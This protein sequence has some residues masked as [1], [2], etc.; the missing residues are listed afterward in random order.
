VAHVFISYAHVD[1]DFAGRLKGEIEKAGFGVWIDTERLRAGEDW[2]TEIDNAVQDSIAL[3]LVM[4]PASLNSKYV[5]YEWA[6]ALGVGVKVVPVLLAPVSYGEV[7]PR[8]EAIQYLN[9]TNFE[10]GLWERLIQRLREV[11]G[12]RRPNAVRVSRDAPP[13]VQHAVTA[14]DSHNPDER[15]VALESLSQMDH[16][17]AKD[18]LVAAMQHPLREVRIDAALRLVSVIQYRDKQ[19]I[20]S[21]LEA[22]EAPNSRDVQLQAVEALGQIGDTEV[23]PIL[24]QRLEGEDE[25]IV[26]AA[27][28]A[29]A[30]IGKAATPNLVNTLFYGRDNKTVHAAAT[31]LQEIGP[32]VVP[33]LLTTLSQGRTLAGAEFTAIQAT[34]ATRLIRQMG[35]DA[36]PILETS[37]YRA[38]DLFSNIADIAATILCDISERGLR[39]VIRATF[40][41]NPDVR[42]IAYHAFR[43]NNAVLL[44]LI[45][46]LHRIGTST[47]EEDN[48][49]RRGATYLLIDD[50]NHSIT[51]L[52]N[53]LDDKDST[54]WNTVAAILKR[55]PVST[56]T[57]SLWIKI[58]N[59]TSSNSSSSPMS[60]LHSTA[61]KQLAEI[62][63][64][65]VPALVDEMNGLFP[66]FKAT[67]VSSETRA[68]IARILGR[69]GGKDAIQALAQA[70]KSKNWELEWAARDALKRIGTP[71]ALEI[72]KRKK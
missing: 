28:T 47:I 6:F 35:D 13:A 38:N 30:S 57:V 50:K 2:R 15:K 54:I 67:N 26:A 36:I 10:A 25:A 59:Q 44:R 1:G 33:I 34:R 27:T 46:L 53:A 42:T 11:E 18:A 66:G 39:I 31:A 56:A 45:Q 40:H 48:T 43:Y 5:A 8:L 41:E 68:Q 62:G 16:P 3:V 58:L 61:A 70:L 60:Q 21:L 52:T 14:L 37:L 9:F 17:T 49:I 24:I 32:T 7:H 69:I 51:A 65:A 64:V 23:I 29:L 63:K 20:P 22:L 19:A 4:S 12:L 71:E 55:M 72:L